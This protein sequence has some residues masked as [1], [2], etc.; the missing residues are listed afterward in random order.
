MSCAIAATEGSRDHCAAWLSGGK[1]QRVALA[2]GRSRHVTRVFQGFAKFQC[3]WR[4]NL[5]R[6][7]RPRPGP[8]AS[9]TRLRELHHFRDLVLAA[10]AFV[11]AC[12]RSGNTRHEHHAG[13]CG[14]D[15]DNLA[16]RLTCQSRSAATRPGNAQILFFGFWDGSAET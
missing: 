10:R 13:S 11:S 5:R 15:H 7:T 8:W 16:V 2:W 6:S 9:P 3:E 14:C 4:N 12:A 1:Q